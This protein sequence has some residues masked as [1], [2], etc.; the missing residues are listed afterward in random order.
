MRTVDAGEILSILDG[1]VAEF[2]EDYV[3]SRPEG[4]SSCYNWHLEEGKPGC[5]I[6]HA[7]SRLGAPDSLLIANEGCGSNMLSEKVSEYLDLEFT[8]RALEVMAMAQS[9]QDAGET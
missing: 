5:I 3:Y 1:L 6:G 8:T 7:M 9:Y 2:G 4:K